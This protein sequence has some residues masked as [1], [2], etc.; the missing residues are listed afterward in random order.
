MRILWT[1]RRLNQSILKETN[2]EYS[3]EGLK[4]KLQYVGHLMWRANSLGKTL[5]LGNIEGRRRRGR[6]RMHRLNGHEFEQ[7][8]GDGEGQG[9]LMCCSP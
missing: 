4:Q 3:L 9:S 1:A 6:Q 7:S 5:V 8:L 2:S